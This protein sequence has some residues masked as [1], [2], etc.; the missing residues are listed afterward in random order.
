MHKTGDRWCHAVHILVDS[1]WGVIYHGSFPA[2]VL[3]SHLSHTAARKQIR[4]LLLQQLGSRPCPQKGCDNHRANRRPHPTPSGGS[5]HN[6]N[7]TLCV[8]VCLCAHVCANA[9]SCPG[10]SVHGIFHARILEWVAISSWVGSFPTQ[11]S[12]LCLLHHRWILYPLSH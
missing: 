11:R 9:L 3:R 1:S 12:H 5:G 2:G 4:G 6:T 8:C 10:S 7:L